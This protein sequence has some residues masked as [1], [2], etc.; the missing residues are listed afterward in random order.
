[1]TT[2]GKGYVWRWPCCVYYLTTAPTSYGLT[3]RVCCLFQAILH[4]PLGA[5]VDYHL[6]EKNRAKFIGSKLKAYLSFANNSPSQLGKKVKVGSPWHLVPRVYTG[7][8]ILNPGV[9]ELVSLGSSDSYTVHPTRIIRLVE[10]DSSARLV[11]PIFR[12]A[13]LN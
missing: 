9:Q 13:A 11:H 10:Q 12:S 3:I 4:I 5:R 8:A 1:M 2:T 6:A 7:C